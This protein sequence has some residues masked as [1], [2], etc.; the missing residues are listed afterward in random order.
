MIE[1]W[2]SEV[3]PATL[4]S[5]V[6]DYTIPAF[7][8]EV[9]IVY[10]AGRLIMDWWPDVMPLSPLNATEFRLQPWG[11]PLVFR[12]DQAGQVTGFDFWMFG[13][14]SVVYPLEE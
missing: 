4:Q 7:P 2:R 12:T 10:E 1:S 5:Y 14:W 3:D 9:S 13:G 8:A 6:G 11:F